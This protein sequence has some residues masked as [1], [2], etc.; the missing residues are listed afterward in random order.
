MP[1]YGIGKEGKARQG[2]A[3]EKGSRTKDNGQMRGTQASPC[4]SK[5]DAPKAAC[6]LGDPKL[7]AA[8]IQDVLVTPLAVFLQSFTSLLLIVVVGDKGH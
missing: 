4:L 7:L 2:K 6:I 1:W 3:R 5:C 8:E